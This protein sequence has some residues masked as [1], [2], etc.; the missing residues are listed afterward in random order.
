[1][2]QELQTEAVSKANKFVTLRFHQNILQICLPAIDIFRQTL[3]SSL[4]D[5]MIIAGIYATPHGIA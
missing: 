2:G 1:M 5:S 4:M 3:R